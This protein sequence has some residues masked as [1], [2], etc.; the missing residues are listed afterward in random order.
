M[1]MIM[2]FLRMIQN[3]FVIASAIVETWSQVPET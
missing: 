1:V 3:N 2:M